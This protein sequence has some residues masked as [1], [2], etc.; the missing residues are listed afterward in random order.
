MGSFIWFK[1]INALRVCLNP[2]FPKPGSVSLLCCQGDWVPG[3][4]HP[5]SEPH[6]LHLRAEGDDL[7]SPTSRVVRDGHEN[8]RDAV[9]SSRMHM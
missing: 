3:T 2:G 7:S 1:L 5:F 9:R 6:H 8:V 4:L